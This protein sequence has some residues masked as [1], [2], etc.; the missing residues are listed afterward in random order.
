MSLRYLTFAL[1][2]VAAPVI[3]RTSM[4][5]GRW[6]SGYGQG[7]T[8]Y[9]YRIDA[10]N[11]FRLFCGAGD[12][13]RHQP[14]LLPMIE[15]K[16]PAP[17]SR[18]NA[19]IGSASFSFTTDQDGR[20]TNAVSENANAFH[21]LLPALGQGQL[22][23]VSYAGGRNLTIPLKGAARTLGREACGVDKPATL[24]AN[25]PLSALGAD[26][27][28]GVAAFDNIVRARGG[29]PGDPAW[30]M[31]TA[32]SINMLIAK[33]VRMTDRQVRGSLAAARKLLRSPGNAAT[34]RTYGSFAAQAVQIQNSMRKAFQ[35]G[36]EC[37]ANDR[38]D[39][40]SSCNTIPK[41]RSMAA[42]AID[43]MLHPHTLFEFELTPDGLVKR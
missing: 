34:G 38:A 27:D 41:L 24:R 21:R 13:F 36:D 23:R 8:E 7:I 33:N 20:I 14:G 3:A 15:G 43:A 42:I 28:A 22:L 11:E 12:T 35:T 5:T 32:L 19:R 30:G 16:N 25:A 18:V 29:I 39:G 10:R 6:A 31:V 26:V 4:I 37:S 2:L 9:F 40:Q 17:G 1:L